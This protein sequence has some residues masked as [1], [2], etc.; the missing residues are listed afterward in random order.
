MRVT[1]AIVGAVGAAAI[2]GTAATGYALWEARQHALRRVSVPVLPPG[3]ADLVVLHLS[4]LHLTAATVARREWVAGLSALQPDLVIVTGDFLSSAQGVDEVALAL[5]GLLDTPGAFVFGSND[6]FGAKPINPTKYF[7][8]PSKL[9]GRRKPQLPTD[10]LRS[11][12]TSGG[13]LDLNNAAGEL[14]VDGLT[15][16][17]RGVCDPHIRYDRY[18]VVAG[19]WPVDADVRLGVSHAPYLRVL[20]AMA[21]DGADVIFA[22][23]THGG[24][25]C[26]PGY[27]ALVTNCDL[28]RQ[29]VSGLS[30]HGESYLH[31]SAGLGTNPYTPIRVACRPEATLLTLT[32]AGA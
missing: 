4:D 15:V 5:A 17:L 7:A 2:G 9:H 10:R 14:R 11:V 22:G 21:D 20:D 27:G 29:R 32:A 8:G 6:Y 24:Q 16:A 31:V 3:A 19:P 13:W 26:L 25:V 1:H 30:R 28:D 18:R 23:H 12:L